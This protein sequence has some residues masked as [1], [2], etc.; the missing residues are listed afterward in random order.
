MAALTYPASPHRRLLSRPDL[1]VIPGGRLPRRPAPRRTAHG[2]FVR[3]RVAVALLVLAFVLA[4][5]AV[6]GGLGGGPL[7]TSEP[8][9]PQPIAARVLVVQPGDTLWSIA[10][11]IDPTG[12]VRDTVRR[13]A[14][15]NGGAAL[16]VGQRLRLP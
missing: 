12:D 4:V 6:S 10:R 16:Q 1:H 15:A 3:R 8:A 13:L 14:D 5:H 9:S 2:T 7:A 11:R